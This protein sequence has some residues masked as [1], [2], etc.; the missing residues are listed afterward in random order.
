MD[1]DIETLIAGRFG[2]SRACKINTE[3][4]QIDPDYREHIKQQAKEW[5]QSNPERRKRIAKKYN[6]QNAAAAQKRY[7]ERKKKEKCLLQQPN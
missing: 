5:N 6:S 2:K 1:T 7:R 4:Y 3:R